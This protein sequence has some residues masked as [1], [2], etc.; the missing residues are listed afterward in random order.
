MDIGI[1]LLLYDPKFLTIVNLEKKNAITRIVRQLNL[2]PLHMVN[3]Q[4]L[5]YI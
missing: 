4:I 2:R 5:Q 1:E 3:L